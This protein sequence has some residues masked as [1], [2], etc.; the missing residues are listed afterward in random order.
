MD[1]P[2]AAY[3]LSLT[4]PFQLVGMDVAG[5]VEDALPSLTLTMRTPQELDEQWSGAGGPPQWRGRLGDGLDLTIETEEASG[6]VLFSYGDRARFRLH[7]DMSQLDCAP[8]HDGLDWQRALISKVLPAISVMLGYEALHGAVVDSPAGVVAIMAPSGMGKSTLAIEMLGRGWP[9]FADDVL[10]L[11]DCDG[12]VRAHPG[13]PHMNVA[14]TLPG[15]LDP[16]DLGSTL[17]VLAGERW[18]AARNT[19]SRPRPV[20]MLCLLQRSPDLTMEARTLTPS[21]LPLAPYM[22]GLSTDSARQRSRFSLYADLMESTALVQLTADPERP[23]AQLA[24]LL[25]DALTSS[26]ELSTSG[27]P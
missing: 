25:E 6:E 8:A 1:T 24:D 7:S 17:G 12:A 3:G 20:R 15:E 5:Q 18:L 2:Y 13:T 26:A 9:L 21:P 16:R 10:I 14:Q 22:L 23:P 11:E 19:T 4:C 27:A